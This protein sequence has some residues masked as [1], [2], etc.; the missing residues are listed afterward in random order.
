[1][2]KLAL[3]NQAGET[4]GNI[5]L[6]DSVFGVESN[7]QVMYDVVKAQRAAMR[8][9][10]NKTKTRTEVRGGGRKP[11]RQKGTGNARQGSI[12][13]PQWVG[14]G[15][16]FGPIPRSYDYKVN[17]KIRRLALKIALSDKVREESLIALD[18]FALEDFKTKGMVQ[19]LNNLKVSGKT[20]LVLDNVNE[21]V[22]IATRNLPNVTT[23]TYDHTSVYDILNADKVVATEQALKMIEEALS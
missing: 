13:A 4:V 2:P 14:G 17:K 6:A 18:K 11:Y 9:G 12:R 8:Q 15:I 1:M 3:L 5:N 23:V 16:V 22:D 7:Q 19:V 21:L 10:T 20:M